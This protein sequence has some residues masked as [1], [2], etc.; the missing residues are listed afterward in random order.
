M[1][2]L[3]VAQSLKGGSA[4]YFNEMLPDHIHAYGGRNV[5]LVVPATDA[6]YLRSEISRCRRFWFK[7][8]ARNVPSLLNFVFT[9]A[10]ACWRFKPDV[11]HLH[12]I[13]AGTAGRLAVPLLSR[14]TKVVY[15]AHGWAL[16]RETSWWVKKITVLV[17]LALAPLTDV[18]VNI[19]HADAA[20]AA[21]AGIAARDNVVVYNGVEDIPPPDRAARLALAQE[22]G[23]SPDKVNV[24]FAGRLDHQK[25][26]EIADAAF[27]ALPANK[28][29]LYVL[30]DSVLSTSAPP[31]DLP[32]NVTRLGWQSRDE[33]CRFMQI[34]DVLVMPSKWEGFGLTAIEAMRAGT[35]VLC[36]KVGGLPEVVDDGVTGIVVDSNQPASYRDALLRMTKPQW[37]VL[38]DAGRRR[39]EALFTSALF[40]AR[41]R[42]VYRR[43]EETNSRLG[44]GLISAARPVA[45]RSGN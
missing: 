13:Y 29:H 32:A 15:C 31:P 42:D 34:A 2:I 17:E 44:T 43:F 28:Y 26:Y 20:C 27:R 7:S 10:T 19:S 12:G 25:G 39:F 23:L 21:A 22:R 14:K 3:H 33:V 11:I 40:T 36:S 4:S 6:E 45:I 38:G 5:G 24:V 9:V 35:A 16:E 30:G 8:R 18:I 41:L 1:K 37:R